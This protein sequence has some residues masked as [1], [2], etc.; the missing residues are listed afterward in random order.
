MCK[1]YRI[2]YADPP[3]D[4][5]NKIGGSGSN[6]KEIYNTLSLK[7]IENLDIQRITKENAIL[8]LWTTDATLE[9]ALQIIKKWGFEYKTVQFIWVKI[10]KN[11]KPVHVI[12]P[13]SSKC[14]EMCLVAT[15]GT[16]QKYI[17]KR[18]KQLIISERGKHSEKPCEARKRIEEMLPKSSK[19]ELFARERYNGW[20]CFG[21]EVESDVKMNV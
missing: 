21:N 2:I 9:N 14:C 17:K 20:D 8:F 15:K 5:S 16:M 13:Y 10:G 1:K 11:K 6:V 19:I 4:F 7:Q 12:S 3:W 18:P